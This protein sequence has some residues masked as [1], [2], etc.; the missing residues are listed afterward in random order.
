MRDEMPITVISYTTVTESA[1]DTVRNTLLPW[2]FMPPSRLSRIQTDVYLVA[3]PDGYVRLST[4]RLLTIAFIHCLSGLDE[5]K[6]CDK[7]EGATG[8]LISG[9]TELVTNRIPAITV[10]WDWQL[11]CHIAG[12]RYVRDGMPRTNLMLIDPTTGA[13]LGDSLTLAILSDLIDKIGRA[14]V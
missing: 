4:E 13:D 1:S 14:H 6:D 11:N 2:S 8:A 7:F 9:Y 3:S 10:G 12:D 5:T